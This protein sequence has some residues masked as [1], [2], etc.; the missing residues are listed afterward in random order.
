MFRAAFPNASDSE[1]KLEVAWVKDNYDLTGNNGSTKDA[2]ITRLAGIW[3][4]PSV[5]L[6]LGKTYMLGRLIEAVV[7][8]KP[9]PNGNYRR[10]GKS[11][12]ATAITNAPM[13]VNAPPAT[14]TAQ[15]A[16]V[17]SPPSIVF[18]PPSA[19]KSL[20]TPSPTAAVNP[21]TKRRKESSPVVES[22]SVVKPPSRQSPA[23]SKVAAPPA[24]NTL[25]RSTRTKSPA[26]HQPSA[27]PPTLRTPKATRSV[28]KKESVTLTTSL[29]PGGSDLTVVD[30]ES[31][32]VEDGVV[33][34]EL[35]DQDIKEQHKLIKG[36]KDK[37]DAARKAQVVAEE[38]MD[39][40]GEGSSP[41]SYSATNGKKRERQDEDEPLKFDFK[42]PEK[43]TR[44]IS[45]NRRVGR[46]NMEPRTKSFAWGLA[47]FAVGMGAV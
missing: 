25:R 43:E 31:L 9:D 15:A 21:P 4:G 45:T 18:K 44:A 23:P 10:S 3:V 28:A 7:E 36:L 13:V 29:T 35:R 33:G 42:E 14:G 8:A 39:V 22:Q 27:P 41:P 24:S 12:A 11:A 5:A 6:E 1:E 37:R 40:G 30:E 47:A 46:F 16:A 20:P 38:G 2:H 32:V 34:A 17:A 26:P 19:A